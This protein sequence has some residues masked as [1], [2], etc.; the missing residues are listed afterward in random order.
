MRVWSFFSFVLFSMVAGGVGYLLYKKPMKEWESNVKYTPSISYLV[1]PHEN[2][3]LTVPIGMRRIRIT[4]RLA[5]SNIDSPPTWWQGYQF[6]VRWKDEMGYTVKENY[7]HERTRTSR[8]PSPE[9]AP[10]RRAFLA[11]FDAPLPDARITIVS[12]QTVLPLGGS[13]EI[14]IPEDG[15]PLYIHATAEQLRSDIEAQQQLLSLATHQ[16][17]KLARRMGIINWSML[18]NDERWALVKHEWKALSPKG[19]I[20]KD[21]QSSWIM[22]SDYELP[23]AY[24]QL[25]G[26]TL[27]SN[28]A[29]ALNLVGPVTVRVSGPKDIKKLHGYTITDAPDAAIREEVE[30]VPDTKVGLNQEEGA[31]SVKITREGPVS[32]HITN[33][34]LS[35][36]G[37]IILSVDDPSPSQFLGWTLGAML[38][39]LVPN[40]HLAKR[41]TAI[42]A[43]EWWYTEFYETREEPIII[44]PPKSKTQ[45][46]II[47]DVR[48]RLES[49]IDSKE[50]S[51]EIEGRN[52]V[53][54][55]KWTRTF[56]F[57][58][59]PA[60]YEYY[61]PDNPKRD[62]STW[63]SERLRIYVPYY[64]DI[65]EIR[66]QSDD[67]LLIIPQA[68]GPP[69]GEQNTYNLP[70]ETA[71]LRFPRYAPSS[72]HR[73]EAI[74][75]DVLDIN[76]QLV[77][78]ASNVRLEEY[79]E[80]RARALEGA[81]YQVLP[82]PSIDQQWL[83]Q[84]KDMQK[85][86]PIYCRVRAGEKSFFR[87]TKR[88]RIKMQ[89][90]VQS[91]VVSKNTSDL[92][93]DF[94]IFF[95][96]T[97]VEA[98]PFIQTVQ[99]HTFF[100]AKDIQSVSFQ[101][102]AG[103]LMWLKQY[104]SPTSQCKTPRRSIAYWPLKTG[105]SHRFTI[106]KTMTMQRLLITAL[107]QRDGLV[108]LTIDDGIARP[109]EA[110]HEG[111]TNREVLLEMNRSPRPIGYQLRT[112]S[113]S[114]GI[115]EARSIL[116][117]SDLDNSTHQVVLKN[118]SNSTIYLRI[119]LESS[120]Q[121]SNTQSQ[122]W[123]Y[124]ELD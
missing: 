4:S 97:S 19:R 109:T 118:L 49:Y 54:E 64:P 89:S 14:S 42:V 121:V 9:E 21:F 43:P 52:K 86:G 71:L 50:R 94:E 44:S 28:R 100:Q 32:L 3:K 22:Q 63:I 87:W 5:L 15:A 60:P 95:D 57:D 45:A 93:K 12:G 38:R 115:L 81:Q 39:D 40:S 99:T 122:V 73:L 75:T 114:A 80:T 59:V 23:W 2:L 77:K 16:K 78:I 62:V 124:S 123:T 34:R 33:K 29:M 1:K 104:G 18:N 47:V 79:P 76:D 27:E 8:F 85:A 24:P 6:R 84:T 67:A 26:T 13:I 69:L 110:L 17:E 88:E 82:M 102:P 48:A 90:S 117:K 37:P 61:R 7:Y 68:I 58:P 107:G 35:P 91:T 119:H 113:L 36:V 66:I 56:Q 108:S 120:E 72:Y 112:P 70:Y 51:I 11:G 46:E 20:G 55:T 41:N 106:D 111:W 98:E 31:Y 25:M 92:G 103:S 10:Y 53:G 30:W 74:N 96:D 101:G 105:A 116:M 83:I 65:S